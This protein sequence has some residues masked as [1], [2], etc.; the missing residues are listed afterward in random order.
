MEHSNYSMNLH[1]Y[2][3]TQHRICPSPAAPCS[4]VTQYQNSPGAAALV[5]AYA[6]QYGSDSDT[7]YSKS[8]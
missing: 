1:S 7:S 3:V 6:A 8:R 4:T 2:T 5:K